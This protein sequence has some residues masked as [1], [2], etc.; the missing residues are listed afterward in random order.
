MADDG[1]SPFL[2]KE[3][4]NV[5]VLTREQIDSVRDAV[6][7][8]VD[9]PEWGSDAQVIMQAM[10]ADERDAWEA[11]M[12]DSRNKNQMNYRQARAKLVARC[13]VDEEGKRLYSDTDVDA[14][15]KRNGAVI[16]RLFEV[17]KRINALE[18]KDVDSLVKNSSAGQSGDSPSASPAT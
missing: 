11:S 9:V 3:V 4:K 5:A 7:E 15:G 17:A 13:L 16:N 6:R 10:G 12:I 18:K 8:Y 14:I 2:R 1:V